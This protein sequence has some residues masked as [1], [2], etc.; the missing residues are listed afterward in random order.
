[1][2]SSNKELNEFLYKYEARATLSHKMFRRHKA[3][4]FNYKDIDQAFDQLAVLP[5]EEEPYVEILIPQDRFR[6]LVEIEKFITQ[7]DRE[8]EWS[9]H[10]MER[11]RKESWV[12]QKNETVRKAYERYQ[13]LLNLVRNDYD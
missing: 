7:A 13:T 8:R 9:K 12:R 3:V 10:E 4:K 5:F 2:D 1:M 11:Q 6:H